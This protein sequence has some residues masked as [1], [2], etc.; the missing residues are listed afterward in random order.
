MHLAPVHVSVAS[1][2][3][4]PQVWD[5]RV[6]CWIWIRV[7]SVKVFLVLPSSL[8]ARRVNLGA[9]SIRLVW[10]CGSVCGDDGWAF[11]IILI[12]L[13][14]RDFWEHSSLFRLGDSDALFFLACKLGVAF[15]ERA[16]EL[17]VGPR[18]KDLSQAVKHSFPV[19]HLH[20]HD[21]SDANVFHEHLHW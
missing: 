12:L 14:G 11:Y 13:V 1:C 17:T 10:N 20:L 4:G 19:A 2:H 18:Y 7:S 15:D 3:A 5:R 21:C 16:K 6:S 8:S 9:F